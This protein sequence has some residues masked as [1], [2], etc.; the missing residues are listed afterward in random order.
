MLAIIPAI[1]GIL[2]C[3][4]VPIGDPERSRIDPEISGVW[5]WLD[6]DDDA[7]YAFE[8]YDKRT[9]LLTGIPIEEGKDADFSDYDL[10]EYDDLVQL[11]E[12][13]AIGDDGATATGTVVY[14]VWRT[15]LGGEWFMTWEPKAEF[16]QDNF[17]PEVWWVFRE[18]RP[19]ANSLDL[20]MVGG[21]LFKGVEETRRAFER[22]IKKN[23]RNPDL[24]DDE[25]LRLVRVQPEHLKF[26]EDLA[27]EIIEYDEL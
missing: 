21:D 9:W 19:D 25:P 13:E 16:N 2:A 7:F 6:S 17:K 11:M 10:D 27:G 15:K 14:K 1:I 5:V 23:A 20:Y 18:D 26:F 4:P 12:D 24:Y 8:P 3:M 22:V